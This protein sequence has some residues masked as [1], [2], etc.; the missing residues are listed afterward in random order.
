MNDPKDSHVEA[1][2]HKPEPHELEDLKDTLLFVRGMGCPN[3]AIRVRNAL[4]AQAGVINAQ[5]DH[6]SGRAL[7]RHNAGLIR[8]EDM[9]PLVESAGYDG[10]HRYRA[11][12]P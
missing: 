4:V 3:C 5:V 12:L 11:A 1:V 8:A 2:S 10:R 6:L 9:L 7:V